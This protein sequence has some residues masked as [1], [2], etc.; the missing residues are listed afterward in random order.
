MPSK[1]VVNIC[2]FDPE[3]TEPL[4]KRKMTPNERDIE[5]LKRSKRVSIFWITENIRRAKLMTA[6]ERSGRFKLDN[7]EGFPW[8]K[9]ICNEN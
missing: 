2:S 3:M 7:S 5:T 8:L 9:V 1:Y 4:P 6:L